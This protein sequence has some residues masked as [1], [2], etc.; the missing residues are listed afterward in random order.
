MNGFSNYVQLIGNLGRDV[1]IRELDNGRTMA[2]ASVATKEVF[3]DKE[4]T[5]RVET[6]WHQVVGWGKVAD[7]MQILLKRGSSVIL[8]GKLKTYFTGEGEGRQVRTQIVVNE[9]RLMN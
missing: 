2:K 6:T 7:M 4:G 1:E 3:R 5:K 8:H 9:F